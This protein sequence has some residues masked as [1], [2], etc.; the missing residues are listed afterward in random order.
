MKFWAQFKIEIA[1]GNTFPTNIPP[2]ALVEFAWLKVLSP[3][4]LQSKPATH[5]NYIIYILYG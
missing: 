5:L 3:F 2:I 4:F 1:I